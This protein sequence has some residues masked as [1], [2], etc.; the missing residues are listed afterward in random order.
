MKGEPLR[1][2]SFCGNFHHQNVLCKAKL[3]QQELEKDIQELKKRW[4][5]LRASS[6]NLVT[7]NETLRSSLRLIVESF[8]SILTPKEIENISNSL[9]DT[10]RFKLEATGL[11]FSELVSG[12]VETVNTGISQSGFRDQLESLNESRSK[13]SSD[14]TE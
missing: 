9:P 6:Y 8:N 4:E 3:V 10:L 7:D 1:W 2:C 5:N 14:Q 13:R 11:K 12:K